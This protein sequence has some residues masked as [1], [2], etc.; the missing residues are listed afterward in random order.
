MANSIKDYHRTPTYDELI[1]EAIIHPTDIVKYQNLI[2]TQLRTTPHLAR[3]HAD[4]F[5]DTNMLNSNSMN[6]NIQ[7]R[8]L[9]NA[10]QP[11][12]RYISTGPEQFDIFDTEYTI[13]QQADD[14][15]SD[16]EEL[17]L[18]N[19]KRERYFICFCK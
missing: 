5:L 1:Q 8:A 18:R 4:V 6:K 7:H 19:K 9:H 15:T 16:L 11:E 10:K 17:Q 14:N 3:L 12:A 13:Q 2:A